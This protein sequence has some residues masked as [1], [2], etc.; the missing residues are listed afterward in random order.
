VKTQGSLPSEDAVLALL[1]G[2]VATGQIV[3]RKLD[4]WQDMATALTSAAPKAEE[5]RLNPDAAGIAIAHLPQERELPP[6]AIPCY[7]PEI[8]LYA[9][10]A[11]TLQPTEKMRHFTFSTAFGTPP[12]SSLGGVESSGAT[13]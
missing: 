2:L 11:A 5:G 12:K 7:P 13:E 4:G 1:F 3:F 10:F 6:R 9:R 8:E